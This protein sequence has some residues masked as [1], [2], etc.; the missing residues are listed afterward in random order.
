MLFAGLLL[1]CLGLGGGA[2]P[3]DISSMVISVTDAAS[4]AR[5]TPVAATIAI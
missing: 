5:P 4:T 2:S 1:C 3:A